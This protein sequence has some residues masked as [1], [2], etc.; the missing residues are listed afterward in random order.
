M[1]LLH[2]VTTLFSLFNQHL[3]NAQTLVKNQCSSYT[4]PFYLTEHQINALVYYFHMLCTYSAL[5][6]SNM[7]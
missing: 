3:L 7:W 5:K 1:L 6:Q 4:Y 2:E